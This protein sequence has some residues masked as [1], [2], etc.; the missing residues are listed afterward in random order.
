MRNLG[1]QKKRRHSLRKPKHEDTWS[2]GPL[3]DLQRREIWRM[4]NHIQ[5]PLFPFCMEEE[6]RV[7]EYWYRDNFTRY[8]L[9]VIGLEGNISFQFE[10]HEVILTRG[11]VLIIPPGTSYLLRNADT[12]TSHKVVIEIIGNNL[13][14]DIATLGLNRLTLI[15]TKDF[16]KLAEWVRE[17]GDLIRKNEIEDIPLLVGLSYR[18]CT[19]L[20]MLLPRAEPDNVLL[21]RAQMILE[22]NFEKKVTIGALAEELHCSPSFLN[23]LFRRELGTTPLQYRLEKK[24]ACARYLLC[25]TT[26]TVKEIA[27][28]LGYC[29]PF[30][31]SGEFRRITGKS[32][33]AARKRKA[34]I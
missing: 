17:I 11:H 31:F 2:D 25:S 24:I 21:S 1:Q 15:K 14:S 6:I 7:G 34:L 27:F 12:F 32:P 4:P 9:I 26:L 5:L 19:S 13:N 28:K 8:L 22:S 3:Y 33:G 16:L 18:F 29:D 23:K 30:Y 10:D 20:S